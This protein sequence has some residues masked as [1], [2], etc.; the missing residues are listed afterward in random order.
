M[1]LEETY[2]ETN[3]LAKK[4]VA[5]IEKNSTR[6][7]WLRAIFLIHFFLRLIVYSLKRAKP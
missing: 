2:G 4:E 6:N 3:E 7:L 1:K 5:N